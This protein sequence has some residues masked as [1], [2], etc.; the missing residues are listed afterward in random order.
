MTDRVGCTVGAL[1]G[2]KIQLPRRPPLAT[3]FILLRHIPLSPFFS[4]SLPFFFLTHRSLLLFS[5]LCV[6]S[7]RHPA[8]FLIRRKKS[9]T[10]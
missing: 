10:N 7:A 2:R 3:A 6:F 5:Y 4:F 9:N 1:R 8:D